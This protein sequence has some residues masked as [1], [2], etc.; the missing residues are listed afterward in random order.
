MQFGKWGTP[1]VVVLRQQSDYQVRGYAQT[2][3]L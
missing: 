1:D 3:V 2:H